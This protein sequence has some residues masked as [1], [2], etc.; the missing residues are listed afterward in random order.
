MPMANDEIVDGLLV[1]VEACNKAAS[2]CEPEYVGHIRGSAVVIM[3]A[4]DAILRMQERLV[5][6]AQLLEQIELQ[7]NR[8]PLLEPDD[9]PG[10]GL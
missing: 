10:L 3:E 9:D 5:R 7:A 6:Q 2:I 4:A 1:F 8:F